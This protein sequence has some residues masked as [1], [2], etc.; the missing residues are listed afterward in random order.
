MVTLTAVS[1][2]PLTSSA[3]HIM[4]LEPS[5]LLWLG[6]QQRM[7]EMGL[8]DALL[9]RV[10]SPEALSEALRTHH[11]DVLFISSVCGSSRV[12]PLLRQLGGLIPAET[13]P[14]VVA[15][16]HEEVPYLTRLL[17]GFGVNRTL[18]PGHSIT[19]LRM[20]LEGLPVFAP[21]AGRP[22]R[23]SAQEKR[24]LLALLSG[25][26]VTRVAGILGK[27][28]GVVSAQ[29]RTIQFKLR[30]KHAEELHLLGGRL[31]AMEGSL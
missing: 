20:A 28:T 11:P 25:Q 10:E 12:L 16:L 24:V 23:F 6:V 3:R 4:V 14:W 5:D 2:G 29:K 31:M 1:S 18:S 19:D 26:G 15:C 17:Q 7:E 8:Q 21:G 30:M 9:W 27:G 13:R 22:V